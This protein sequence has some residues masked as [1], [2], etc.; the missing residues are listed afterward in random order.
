VQQG[1]QPRSASSPYN[2]AGT[3]AS[4]ARLSLADARTDYKLNKTFP[5]QGGEL[6]RQLPAVPDVNVPGCGGL[7]ENA[8]KRRRSNIYRPIRT[9]LA[10]FQGEITTG[11]SGT[12]STIGLLLLVA[13]NEAIVQMLMGT[14]RLTFLT[15]LRP[16]L[17]RRDI[18]KWIKLPATIP[19][20]PFTAR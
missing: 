5:P 17:A 7:L 1:L 9:L 14:S 4:W 6:T 18:D 10:V 20:A 2:S 16:K 13:L 11:P 19:R 15:L 8:G 12:R 3:H